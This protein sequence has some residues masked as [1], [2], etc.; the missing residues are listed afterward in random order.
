MID[1]SQARARRSQRGG[2]QSVGGGSGSFRN[3]DYTATRKRRRDRWRDEVRVFTPA[4]RRAVAPF[5]PRL[6]AF[7][8]A[9]YDDAIQNQRV[10]IA[11]YLI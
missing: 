3:Y 8:Y 9:L 6:K 11:P 10:A 1:E 4:Q 7:G 5:A 2:S